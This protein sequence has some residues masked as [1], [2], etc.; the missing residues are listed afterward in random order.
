MQLFRNYIKRKLQATRT[1]V[2]TNFFA[3]TTLHGAKPQTNIRM[4]LNAVILMDVK[5]Y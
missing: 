3:R 4:L 1:Q 2:T 5:K